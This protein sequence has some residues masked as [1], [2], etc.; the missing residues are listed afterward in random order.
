MRWCVREREI[1]RRKRETGRERER[2]SGGRRGKEK[3]KKSATN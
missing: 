2:E 3:R 1:K